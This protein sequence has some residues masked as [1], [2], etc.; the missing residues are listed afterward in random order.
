[1]ANAGDWF[2][3]NLVSLENG[4]S[5]EAAG[6][7]QF[8]FTTEEGIERIPED[9]STLIN[10]SPVFDEIFNE[11]CDEIAV[12]DVPIESFKVFLHFFHFSQA[13]ITNENIAD[14]MYLANKYD[15][16]PCMWL[17]DLFITKN[18]RSPAFFAFFELVVKY[19]RVH[20][21]STLNRMFCLQAESLLVAPMFKQ[22]AQIVLKEVLQ[23]DSLVCAPMQIFFGCMDWA[24]ESCKANNLNPW[25][26]ENLRQQ[27]AECLYLIPFQHMNQHDIVFCVKHHKN[28]FNAD[29]VMDLLE[30]A[31]SSEPI[32]S[33]RFPYRKLTF[34]PNI[35]SVAVV[36]D[37]LVFVGG[38]YWL[39]KD[40]IIRYKTENRL[41]I[42]GITMAPIERSVHPNNA[43]QTPQ[44][45]TGLLTISGTADTGHKTFLNQYIE[46][47]ANLPNGQSI[48]LFRPI[49]SFPFY[50]YRAWFTFD[51]SWQKKTHFVTQPNASIVSGFYGKELEPVTTEY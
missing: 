34:D 20:L 17:C 25:A 12:E 49:P 48:E 2:Y 28:L 21:K 23:N 46:L 50:E 31:T 36:S 41:L 13:N 43:R 26:M 9:K 15:V 8:V 29:E 35:L 51:E 40:E 1:M 16:L 18:A 38:K 6:E 30:I 22:C 19:N 11:E 39:K 4:F 27:L 10:L 45:L 32:Q 14:I 42:T 44:K 24:M 5:D 33:E 37:P 3:E 47:D 7:V